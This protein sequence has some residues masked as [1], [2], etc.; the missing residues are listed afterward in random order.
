MMA[1]CTHV[2]AVAR[3]H[4]ARCEPANRQEFATDL[5][6]C[7][8]GRKLGGAKSVTQEW[9]VA[10]RAYRLRVA[11]RADLLRRAFTFPAL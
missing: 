7:S 9:D 8:F 1:A 11:R 5:A 4:Y 10:R 6:D 3:P 2:L